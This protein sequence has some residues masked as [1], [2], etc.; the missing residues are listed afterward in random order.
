MKNCALVLASLFVLV[1][2]GS[3]VRSATADEPCTDKKI[4]AGDAGIFAD[5]AGEYAYHNAAAFA[6]FNVYAIAFELEGGLLGYELSYSFDGLTILGTTFTG[7]VNH[8]DSPEEFIVTTGECL[9]TSGAVVLVR[10]SVGS[11]S[12]ANLTDKLICIGG[13]D[14]SS[15]ADF[16][17]APGY[18]RC[19]GTLRPF[20]PADNCS[21]LVPDG[22][23][24]L[25]P[26]V[27]GWPC[28]LESAS[29]GALKARF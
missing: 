25:N 23:L 17:R 6:P 12:G 9:E 15:F 20:T 8:A 5:A 2:G 29:I 22:C 1:T 24:I 26:T 7:S 14:P 13:T 4:A 28:P 16:N 10:L 27:G 18:L 3:G 19:D 11:F 21:A